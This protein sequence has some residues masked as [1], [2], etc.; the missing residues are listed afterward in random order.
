MFDDLND[1]QNLNS[2]GNDCLNKPRWHVEPNNP[3]IQSKLNH[4]NRVSY[5]YP[6]RFDDVELFFNLLSLTVIAEEY[7]DTKFRLAKHR[8]KFE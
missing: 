3:S 1:Q 8:F 6:K 7:S 4:P 2:K 5:Q